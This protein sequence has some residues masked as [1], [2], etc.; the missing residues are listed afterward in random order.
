MHEESSRI[1][2]KL[3]R[4]NAHLYVKG[5]KEAKGSLIERK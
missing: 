3:V 5:N 4:V 1:K 2:S